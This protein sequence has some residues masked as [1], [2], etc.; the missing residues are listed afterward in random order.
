MEERKAP[1]LVTMSILP[2]PASASD[3]LTSKEMR[4]PPRGWPMF[5]C[6]THESGSAFCADSKR[7]AGEVLKYQVRQLEN[8]IYELEISAGQFDREGGASF[9]PVLGIRIAAG[10]DW[11]DDNPGQAVLDLHVR[12]QRLIPERGA[13]LRMI[14]AMTFIIS[15]I[16]RGLAP[17]LKRVLK[18]YR[19]G[20]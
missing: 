15:R 14:L 3:R 20:Q 13:V 7:G 8:E 4:W 11:F 9:T 17:S 6:V 16:D 5:S 10:E 1:P 12:G 2:E 19:L 18:T